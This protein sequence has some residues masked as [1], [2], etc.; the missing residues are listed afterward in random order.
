MPESLPAGV[1]SDRS[2]PGKVHDVVIVGSGPAGYTAA[3]YAARAQLDT[4]L[5]EGTSRGGALMTT[6]LVDNYPGFAEGTSGPGLVRHL[7]A[8]AERFGA[9]LHFGD[10]DTFRLA[11]AVKTVGTAANT[12]HSRAVILAMGSAPRWLGVPGEMR[13]QGRGIGFTAK[14]DGLLLRDKD[15]AVVGGGDAAMEEALFSVGIARSV[16][17]VHHRNTFRSSPITTARVR[18]HE[19]ISVL[20]N[21]EVVAIRG[22]RRVT[23][24]RLRQRITGAECDLP[25]SAVIVAVGHGPRSELLV[26]LLDLDAR[27]YV[28][29][30]D[31][32]SHT[33]VDGVFAAGDLVDRRYRQAITAAASGCAAALDAE[34]WLAATG[35]ATKCS[36]AD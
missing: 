6:T 29:T 18:T 30:P 17:I 22:E 23:G 15:V 16:T 11:G 9:R 28:L 24:L 12:L 3:I 5:I 33:S 27:G 19:K 8:Q 25:V 26:G 13:L 35:Y 14:G 21:T 32:T 4:V 36:V 2:R 1:F 10:V 20:T 31:A 34:R 7:R